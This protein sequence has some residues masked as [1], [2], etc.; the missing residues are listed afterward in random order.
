MFLGLRFILPDG[1]EGAEPLEPTDHDIE[2]V[3]NVWEPQ[4]RSAPVN[5]RPI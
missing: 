1:L 5:A 4:S 2:R 3:A